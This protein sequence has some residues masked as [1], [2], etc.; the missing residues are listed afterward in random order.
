MV[1]TPWRRRNSAANAASSMDMINL[2]QMVKLEGTSV[3]RL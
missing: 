3:M 2:L 1:V